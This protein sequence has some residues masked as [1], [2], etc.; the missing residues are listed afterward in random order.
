MSDISTTS[1][2]SPPYRNED[3]SLAL[4]RKRVTSLHNPPSPAAFGLQITG[5]EALEARLFD[6]TANAKVLTS[7]VAMHMDREWRD[8]LF[9]QLDS[10]H[11]PEEWDPEDRPVERAS[12]ATFLK[13]ILALSPTV[14]P[15]LGLSQRGYLLA[16]WTRAR[17]RLTIEFLPKDRV[18]WVIS[19]E[20]Q[21]EEARFAGQVAVSRLVE[22]LKPY[23][24]ERWLS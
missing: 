18:R 9:R 20:R 5:E 10:L 17:D 16:A 12:F 3:K 7:Q 4:L 6:A 1:P 19:D 24:P 2:F 13:A 14:R 15:G 21:G 23:E 8:R 22:S 11:D